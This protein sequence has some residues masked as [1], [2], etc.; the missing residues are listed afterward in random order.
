MPLYSRFERK[1]HG[2]TTSHKR[3]SPGRQRRSTSQ[4]HAHAKAQLNKI[5]S[6]D[7]AA[8]AA[9]A[10]TPTPTTT[11]LQRHRQTTPRNPVTIGLDSSLQSG[12]GH[13]SLGKL[14]IL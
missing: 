11:K 7:Q 12:R 5:M 9:A 14:T 8:A 6:N 13:N 3:S 10:S 2:T 1:L 4:E